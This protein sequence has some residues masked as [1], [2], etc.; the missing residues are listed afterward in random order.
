VLRVGVPMEDAVGG[1]SPFD[2]P[3]GSWAST[4]HVG[5]YDVLPLAYTAL[6]DHVH[7]RGHEPGGVVCE[8]YLTDPGTVAEE[9]L[10]TALAMP[11]AS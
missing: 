1:T 8:S 6:L 10:V 11:L 3:G 7:E 4:L 9:E 2:H 5:A